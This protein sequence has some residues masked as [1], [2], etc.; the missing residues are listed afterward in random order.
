MNDE[1]IDH[2][3]IVDSNRELALALLHPGAGDIR[4]RR[5]EWTGVVAF[6]SAVHYVNAYLW[7]RRQVAPSSH[8]DRRRLFYS[9]SFLVPVGRHYQLLQAYGYQA[10]YEVDFVASEAEARGIVGIDLRAVEAAVLRALGLAVP[11]WQ[12][13]SD[14]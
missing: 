6:Y 12:L 14:G 1:T 3:R 9:D 8:A 2:L 4:P 7:E 10:R 13:P 11:T 5:W